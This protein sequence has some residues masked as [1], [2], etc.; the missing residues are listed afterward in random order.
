MSVCVL[1]RAIVVGLGARIRL[2]GSYVKFGKGAFDEVL[3][4]FQSIVHS[5]PFVVVPDK[6]EAQELKD[7]LAICRECVVVHVRANLCVLCLQGLPVLCRS[8][9]TTRRLF[10][11]F[12][13]CRYITAVRLELSRKA[14][15]KE[16]MPRQA[17]LSAMLASCRLQPSHLVLG[18]NVAMTCA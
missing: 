18:L 8:V 5:I 12:H 1:T 3:Q 2:C 9:L 16:E 14:L 10:V 13:A 6:S 15:G 11:R 4:D 7:L 17:E